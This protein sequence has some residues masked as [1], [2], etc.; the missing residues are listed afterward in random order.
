MP[1]IRASDKEF[2]LSHEEEDKL[3]QFQ[4][5]SNFPEEDLSLIV[6]LLRNRGW[7]LEAALSRY[8]DGNW[9]DNIGD[10]ATP[11]PPQIPS[12]PRED[13]TST[14][15]VAS[16]NNPMSPP[17]PFMNPYDTVL[18][19]RNNSSTS[20]FQSRTLI[21]TLPLVHRLPAD[22]KSKFQLVGLDNG[23]R[24][25]ITHNKEFLNGVNN[26]T[27]IFYLIF[28]F[29]PHSIVK[30]FS[31]FWSVVSKVFT[32]NEGK[33]NTIVNRPK[34][35]R[36]PKYP[37]Q[38]ENIINLEKLITVKD[39][40]DTDIDDVKNITLTN[41]EEIVGLPNERLPFNTMLDICENDFKF[42]LVILLGEVDTEQ[43]NIDINSRKF[44]SYVLGDDGVMRIL[45]DY[46]DN[47]LVYMGSVN[48]I[49]PWLVAKNLH[50]K[51][52]P[53]CFLI[54]NV[55]NANGSVNGTTK[56]SVL[57]KLK[58]TSPRRL[59]NSLKAVFDR[60]N[61]ELVVSRTE[62]EDLRVAREIK[63]LQEQ[64][65]QESLL[66]DQLKEEQRQLKLREEQNKELQARYKEQELKLKETYRNLNWLSSCIDILKEDVANSITEINQPMEKGKYTT[67]QFR[68]S[69]GTRFVRKFVDNTTLHSIYV[70]IGC[71]LY[72]QN[73]SIDVEEWSQ[74]IIKKI[75][76]LGEND[77]VLCFKDTKILVDEL[78]SIG[79]STLIKDE[80]ARL[81]K[82]RQ[83]MSMEEHSR[84]FEISFDFELVSPF[85]RYKVPV[86]EKVTVKEVSQ[87]WPNGSLLVED[88]IEDEEEEISDEESENTQ[89]N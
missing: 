30:I 1:V 68:T 2:H 16:S 7:N 75:Q 45:R 89:D 27:N 67:L 81:D 43:D 13:T 82:L 36:L 74:S 48:E 26:K 59:Q 22:Y 6:K 69:E 29:I 31:L 85:P 47:L 53:E 9:K 15:S 79:L 76:E 12:L 35:F 20:L 83:E 19:R 14:T 78:D 51:Y 60:Y 56:L 61:A 70:N 25:F 38:D 23:K 80:L 57:N 65:Y 5:V 71:H 41:V 73:T 64:A 3:N 17:P 37:S 34:I 86:E 10:I 42:L 21:P 32:N 63:H 40:D 88:I 33:D 50:V 4:A 8:F 54:G 84:P 11:P 24:R 87:L 55:L 44:L 49:E 66:K 52:T 58:I 28:L 72:L 18:P 46:K 62:K 77:S 39:S